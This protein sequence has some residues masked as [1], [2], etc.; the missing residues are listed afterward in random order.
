VCLVRRFEPEWSDDSYLE[1][2]LFKA[3]IS[4]GL[5]HSYK[6]KSLFITFKLMF[7]IKSVDLQNRYIVDFHIRNIDF[8]GW[9]ILVV[10]YVE[11]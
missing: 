2:A 6:T 9:H 4:E 8:Q 11:Y 10:S 1:R 3:R 7:R 5:V